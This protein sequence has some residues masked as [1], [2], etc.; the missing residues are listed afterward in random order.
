MMPMSLLFCQE[1]KTMKIKEWKNGF[2]FGEEGKPLFYSFDKDLKD[3]IVVVYFIKSRTE[4]EKTKSE[5]VPDYCLTFRKNSIISDRA[6][7]KSLGTGIGESGQ[8]IKYKIKD[9]A[10]F[11]STDG[12]KWEKLEIKYYKETGKKD[13]FGDPLILVYFDCSYFSGEYQL[14]FQP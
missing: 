12:K 5:I 1:D 3:R 6:H 7:K 4:V 11:V 14:V 13:K 9:N 8:K 10:G 2:A